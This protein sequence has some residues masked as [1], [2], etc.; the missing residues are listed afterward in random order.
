[1]SLF[2][3]FVKKIFF[4]LHKP[5][6]LIH[7]KIFFYNSPKFPEERIIIP[8]Y[9]ETI[10]FGSNFDDELNCWSIKLPSSVKL[11]FF[12]NKFNSIIKTHIFFKSVEKIVFGNSFDKPFKCFLPQLKSIEFGKSFRQPIEFV[13]YKL[14]EIK[15][16][17][18]YKGEFKKK[19]YDNK[20]NLYFKEKNDYFLKR[21]KTV[22]NYYHK[23]F[24]KNIYINDFKVVCEKEC[25]I[26]Y[27]RECENEIR[28]TECKNVFIIVC[29]IC[30]KNIKKC[31]YCN[32]IL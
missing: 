30:Y 24:I 20:I 23:E 13:A 21:G 8:E 29:K 11:I 14:E 19:F 22:Q 15:F 27:N 31:L 9:I 26:C 6:I 17:N 16:N 3:N 12:G 2:I 28:C 7:E 32:N 10:I 4:K 25:V 1:M 5:D 18:N